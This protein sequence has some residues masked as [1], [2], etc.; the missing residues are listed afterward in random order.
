M[1]L[2]AALAAAQPRN[3]L[4]LFSDDQR[5]DTI[6]ALGNDHIETPNL[7]SLVRRGT[8]FTRAY[9]MG[10]LQG[11]VCVPSRAMLM[12][13]RPLWR[14]D[15]QMK[16]QAT[17]PEQFIQSGYTSFIT[18]K[19]HNGPESLLRTFPAGGA[20]FLGGMGDPFKLAFQDITADHRLTRH[21]TK[22][23]HH[24]VEEIADT[25]IH[26]LTSRRR[27]RPFLLYVAMEA[28]HDPR[29][30]PPEFHKKYQTALPPLPADFLPQH[31]FDN[32]EMTVRDEKLAP[33]PRTA[34]N[35]RSQLADY[36]ALITFMDSQI[37]RI[38]K[39]LESTGALEDT[40]VVFSSDQGLA[41]GSHGLMGKQ[42]LYESGMKVPLI[43]AGPDIPA[44]RRSD[45]L[46]YLID[47]YPTLGEL[48]GVKP[49]AGSEGLSLAG[50]LNG[51]TSSHRPWIL[52]GYRHVQRAITDGR[53]KLIRYPQV[54][55]T[56]L[57]DLTTD[58]NELKDLSA[59]PEHAGQKAALLTELRHQQTLHGDTLPLE[60]PHPLPAAWSPP[61][62]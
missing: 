20:L 27:D 55:V 41:L 6:H 36:Y 32:G 19:W 39:A 2:P 52:T 21:E 3:I 45:A 16:G 58:P 12:T 57:F 10:G 14:I 48:N 33:W 38:L 49:P 29:K 28:P 46:C 17:W 4:F 18:G 61:T 44:G 51:K 59:L 50:V 47:I 11:A 1:A 62:Q 25:A 9:C 30:A 26:F 60:V 31:P 43:I 23:G 56:Q 22:T 8:A 54:N 7:D 15:E 24:A 34:E 37:G 35:I 40:L 42:N 5:A 53:W 13:G